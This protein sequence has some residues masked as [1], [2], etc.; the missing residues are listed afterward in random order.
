MKI[1][2]K[3]MLTV[4]PVLFVLLFSV[5]AATYHISGNAL[6]DLAETWLNA[7]LSRAIAM[8]GEQEN[9]LKRYRLDNISASVAK[10]QLDADK[11]ISSITFGREGYFFAVN[12]QGIVMVHPDKSL[13]GRDVSRSSWFSR[14]KQARSRLEF[15]FQGKEN[16]AVYDYFEPWGWF[17]F[18]TD[19]KEDFYGPASRIKTLS[20]AAALAG[21]FAVSVVLFVLTRFLT[22]PLISLARG[23]ETIGG[24]DLGTRIPVQSRDELGRLAQSF[25]TMAGQLEKITV[26]RDQLEEEVARRRKKESELRATKQALV[27]DIAARKAAE[28]RVR[29]TARQFQKML[30]AMPDMITIQDPDMNIVYSNIKGVA[31]IAP[32]KR[33]FKDKC[34]KVYHDRERMCENCQAKIVLKTRKEHETEV[35]CSDGRWQRII[36]T[37]L[38][39]EDNN[40][41]LFM[42]WVRDITEHKKLEASLVQAQR[43]KTVGTLAGGIAH[44]FNNILMGIQGNS[45]LIKMGKGAGNPDVKRLERIEKAVKDAS[46]LTQQLLGFARGGQY[47]PVPADLNRLVENQARM[48]EKAE[49]GITIT[50]K[51]HQDLY[52]VII[53]RAQI[54]Q[55]VINI[56]IN[57]GDAM[58]KGGNIHVQT[59]NIFIGKNHSFPFEITP[60]RYAAL[61]VSDTGSGMDRRVKQRVFEP[62]FTTRTMTKGTGLGLASAYGIIK[63]H[64]GF[65]D[66]D[67]EQEIGTTFTV[68]LPGSD[69]DVPETVMPLSETIHGQGTVP[70]VDGEQEL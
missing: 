56:Y 7:R 24:G 50:R 37:P 54:E 55:V 43:M 68:Y 48:F 5:T 70:G 16:L 33:V 52:P 12:A 25:N 44:N 53:D 69:R 49:K 67:S 40:V 46:Y 29:E 32:D 22:R 10:A 18:A 31:D 39:D 61:S 60:G 26:S 13:L 28:K 15:R 47:N 42:K 14:V 59:Q 51:Y 36:I 2:T 6:N 11:I 38:L 64:G 27:K 34:H 45:S 4:L 41:E 20:L 30:N 21:L 9:S 19:P 63:N 58:P 65:I 57:A 1:Y 23:A 17:V 66:V 3:I 62:F 35:K 8:L